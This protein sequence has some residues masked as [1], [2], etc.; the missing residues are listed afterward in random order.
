MIKSYRRINFLI[1][2]VFSCLALIPA[3]LSATGSAASSKVQEMRG[4][5]NGFIQS[6]NKP[7]EMTQTVIMGQ[8]NRRFTGIIDS[9][10]PHS[11]EGTVAASGKVNYQGRSANNHIIGKSDLL[12]FGGGAAI[13]NGSLTRQTSGHRFLV[14]CVLVMRPF[15]IDPAATG[16]MNPSGR[17]EGMI[18]DGDGTSGQ[19]TMNLLSPQQTSFVGSVDIVLGGQTHTFQL[20]GTINGRGRLIAIAH[21]AIAGHLILD[22][23]LIPSTEPLQGPSI[24]G[25]LSLEMG[26][27]TAFEGTVQTSLSV[28]IGLDH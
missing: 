17:F 15:S 10:G 12:D 19:I 4:V 23:T 21:K 20:L 7:A 18:N 27:G 3:L 13:L 26:D 16:V 9:D 14:P 24:N 28:G 8:E 22:A 25:S 5:W 2:A 1:I 6:D 11:I